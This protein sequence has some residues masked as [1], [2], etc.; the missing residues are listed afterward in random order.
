MSAPTRLYVGRLAPSTTRDDISD[1]FKNVG[2]L[3]DVRVLNGFGF[4]EFED[5]RDADYAVRDYDGTMFMGDRIIVQPAKQPARRERE[6]DGYGRGRDRDGYGP[7]RD[8][9]RDEPPRDRYR[10]ERR[11]G[12]RRGQYRIIVFNLPSGTSWQ[13]LK[14][15]GREHG[16]VTFSDINP[17]RSDEGALEFETRED[18]ERALARIEGTELRGNRLRAEPDGEQPPPEPSYE[19]RERSPEARDR[20]RDER[21]RYRD[22]RPPPPMRDD[23]DRYADEPRRD[24]PRAPEPEREPVPEPEREPAPEPEREPE[25]EPA[26]EPESAPADA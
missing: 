8:R 25:R 23:D 4:V 7:P 12:P 26:P 13:D 6:R 19:R 21:D 10:D 2:R 16:H 24:E 20:Y 5:P 9:Y 1:L 22:E 18:Y 11:R 15:V 14:D 17:Y 3:V